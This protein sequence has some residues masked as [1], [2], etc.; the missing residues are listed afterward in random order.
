MFIR[1]SPFAQGAG[2]SNSMTIN[3]NQYTADTSTLIKAANYTL[4]RI[5]KEGYEY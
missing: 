2:Y 4:E 3:L 1:T 5:F